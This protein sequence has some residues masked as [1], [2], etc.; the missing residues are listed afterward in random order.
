[1]ARILVIEDDRSLRELL[2][3]HLTALGHAVRIAPDAAEGIRHLLSHLPDLVL[4][5]VNMPY[6][7]G[8]ELLRA[9]RGDDI[10]R[11]IPVVLLTARTDDETWAE[12]MR[13]GVTRYVTKP[14]QLQELV[15]A[16]ERAL[17]PAPKQ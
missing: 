13:L 16:V 4:S 9:I 5:D 14:V 10:S 11:H 2:R 8:L 12:A 15:Q 17:K 6:M 3:V 1:M 7:N